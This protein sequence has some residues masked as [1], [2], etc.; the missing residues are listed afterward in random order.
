MLLATLLTTA[1][2]TVAACGASSDTAAPPST[3]PATTASSRA[4]APESEA[5]SSTET[6]GAVSGA[7]ALG[8]ETGAGRDSRTARPGATTTTEADEAP[9]GDGTTDEV[10]PDVTWSLSAIDY[11]GEDG[12]EITYDCPPDGVLGSV[13][14]TGTYTDDSSV[15]TAAVHFGLI[16]RAG[17]GPVVIEISPGLEAYDAST[18]NGVTSSAYGPWNGSFTF[19][20][21]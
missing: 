2:L 21:G 4:E 3:V 20:V 12:L 10:A 16:T 14:G 1:A 19:T 18:A 9:A 6:P 7:A 15:C 17:G 11:R 8:S 5:T 13:W